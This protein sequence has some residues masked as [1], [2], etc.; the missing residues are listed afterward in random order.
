[1]SNMVS[2]N[3]ET[4]GLTSPEMQIAYNKVRADELLSLRERFYKHFP[5]NHNCDETFENA[6]F[7]EIKGLQARIKNLEAVIEY[8]KETIRNQ[9]NANEERHNLLCGVKEIIDEYF[10]QKG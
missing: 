7:R 6:V 3:Q 1:M 4:V 10:N 9:G 2:Q 8:Q 5:I